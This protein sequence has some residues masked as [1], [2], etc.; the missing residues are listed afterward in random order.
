[1]AQWHLGWGFLLVFALVGLEAGMCGVRSVPKKFRDG[2]ARFSGSSVPEK[3][4][5]E[6]ARCDGGRRGRSV[7]TRSRVCA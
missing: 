2:V 6:A 1:M 3:P 5:I 7:Q 4:N